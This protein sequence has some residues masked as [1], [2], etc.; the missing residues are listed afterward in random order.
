M[1]LSSVGGKDD[2]V[3]ASTRARSLSLKA[4]AEADGE[5]QPGCNNCSGSEVPK[6]EGC[7]KGQAGCAGGGEEDVGQTNTCCSARGYYYPGGERT[8]TVRRRKRPRKGAGAGG[9]LDTTSDQ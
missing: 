6:P 2:A 1:A 8:L 5:D 4:R 7:L 3:R 9:I